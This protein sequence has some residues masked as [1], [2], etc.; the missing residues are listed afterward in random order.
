MAIH[1]FLILE[2]ILKK[3]W[4]V[5][6]SGGASPDVLIFRTKN[7]DILDPV[8]LY[9]LISS[10]LFIDYTCRASKGAKMPRGD[11]SA[12]MAY[13]VYTPND[14]KEQ[15]R[16]THILETSDQKIQLNTQ[17]NQTL[18]QMA[19]ALFK[20]WF[21][22]FDTVYAKQKILAQGGTSEQAEHA[23]MQV[24]S[25]KNA[26][27][28]VTMATEQPEAYQS[29]QQTA[30]LFPSELMESELGLIP[31]GW[32]VEKICET[33]KITK[34]KS[35][36]NNELNISNTAL[37]T[38]K[39]FKR[40]GDT[41]SYRNEQKVELGNLIVSYTDVTQQA[42]IIGKPTI[43]LDNRNYKNLVISLDVGVIRPNYI[44]Y[45]YF[46]YFLF[47]KERFQ[48][49]MKSF[50]TG[51]TV[52]H[53]SKEAIPTFSFCKPSNDIIHQFDLIGNSHIDRIIKNVKENNLLE[54]LR[55]TLLPN[56]FQAV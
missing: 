2:L 11:K 15:K 53:L 52:L 3:V 45:K 13:K 30:A 10:Q 20:S 39:S 9:Y 29:P 12:I 23:S 44:H 31:K 6:F 28:L 17:I 7:K 48:N 19:Q 16:V 56:C 34:G 22:D 37:V 26:N 46:L 55:D 33:A 27:A 36:K 51:T 47:T 25:G 38:L 43:I 50:I 35:Y 49:H 42:D 24:I 54:N 40:G 14:I 1:C 5:E 18:E 8:Y 4:K 32:E 21:V 41:G